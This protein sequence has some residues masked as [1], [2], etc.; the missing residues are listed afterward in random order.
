[1]NDSDESPEPWQ[2]YELN[3]HCGLLRAVVRFN[4]QPMFANRSPE[5]RTAMAMLN[6][7]IVAGENALEIALTPFGRQGPEQ[8]AF[9]AQVMKVEAGQFSSDD[10]LLVH[11]RWSP[12]LHPLDDKAPTVVFRHTFHLDP[13]LPPWRWQRAAP[14]LDRDRPA[15]VSLVQRFERALADRDVDEL[16]SLLETKHE[17]VGR[18][19]HSSMDEQVERQREWFSRYFT[20]ADTEVVSV[21]PEQLR[22][23][24]GAGGRV[25]KI[26]DPEGEPPIRVRFGGRVFPFQMTVA[27]LGGTWTIVR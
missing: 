14:Y 10:D 18:A 24:S 26:T 27:N 15:I 7:W 12:E 21:A 9:G 4:D 13:S 16:L 19:I 17:E 23:Q 3:V 6:P 8:P 5:F 1:M 25:V 2:V 20:T 11:F 22:L